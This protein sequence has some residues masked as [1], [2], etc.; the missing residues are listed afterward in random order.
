MKTR[1]NEL[2]FHGVVVNMEQMEV[3]IGEKGWHLYQ[4]IRH[5]GGGGGAAAP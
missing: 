2:L 5:P 1:N 3:K 4:V